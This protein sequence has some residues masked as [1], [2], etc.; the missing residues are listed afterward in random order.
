MSKVVLAGFAALALSLGAPLETHAATFDVKAFGA[1]ADGKTL[2]RDA[3]NKAIDAAAAAGGG[4]VYFPA[5]TYVTG[6]IR[7]RSN[8]TLQLDTGPSSKH[9][10]IRPPTIRRAKPVGKV[11]GVRP[12]PLAQQPDLGRRPRKCIHRGRRPDQ[13]QGALTARSPATGGDKAIALKLCRNV[14]LRD[15]SILNGGHFGDS[16]DGRRQPDHRQRQDRHQPRRH[17][18]RCLPQRQDLQ[19]Q[20][21]LAER[22]RHRPESHP[23]ARDLRAPART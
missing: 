19:R 10:P 14:T 20:R 18:C 15:F 13:R 22:R 21:Q 23:R 7:L 8:I 4:T 5:G 9:R 1:K 6:S 17:R 2:D 12:Q 16:G 3:I 11:P